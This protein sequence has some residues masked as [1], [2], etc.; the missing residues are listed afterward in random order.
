VELGIHSIQLACVLLY[1]NT[2][3][4]TNLMQKVN[5]NPLLFKVKTL[6][7]NE[8]KPINSFEEAI[9]SITEVKDCIS[10]FEGIKTIFKNSLESNPER[11]LLKE[12]TVLLSK[13]I[14]INQELFDTL[15]LHNYDFNFLLVSLC[16]Y[17]GYFSRSP[18]NQ[19]F[20]Y[21][22]MCLLQRFSIYSEFANDLNK[23]FDISPKKFME[24]F[25][26][27]YF[28]CYISFVYDLIVK[29]KVGLE[30]IGFGILSILTN[31]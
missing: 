27:S 8:D 4:K 22:A 30:F 15:N 6:I 13:I 10:L 12:G 20:T 21:V 7:S 5:A 11:S 16:E 31:L 29:H 14:T 18:G 25:N 2:P 28:D 24:C 17:I 23:D 1:F 9:K 26:G 3:K 19:A